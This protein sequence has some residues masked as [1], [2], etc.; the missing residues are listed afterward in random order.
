VYIFVTYIVLS[1]TLWSLVPCTLLEDTNKKRKK[2]KK[3]TTEENIIIYK[4]SI[5]I[6]RM[7]F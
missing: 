1:F 3:N 4:T 6:P 5:M 2:K 7:D